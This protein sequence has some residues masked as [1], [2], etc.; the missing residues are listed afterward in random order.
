MEALD[1]DEDSDFRFALGLVSED[2]NGIARRVCSIGSDGWD[3]MEG[4]ARLILRADA[5]WNCVNF[6]NYDS[7]GVEVQLGRGEVPTFALAKVY[8]DAWG[9]ENSLVDFWCTEVPFQPGPLWQ[10]WLSYFVRGFD[11][12]KLRRALAGKWV[13]QC[14]F[15]VADEQC[16]NSAHERLEALLKLRTWL[17]VGVRLSDERINQLLN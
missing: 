17:R 3:E 10:F 4:I 7:A 9:P 15:V 12:D 1:A 14:K 2:D 5:R 11:E 16:G 13:R 8:A 6:G